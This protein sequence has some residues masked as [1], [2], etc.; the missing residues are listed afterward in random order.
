M[1]PGLGDVVQRCRV[2]AMA[3]LPPSR[4][5]PGSGGRFSSGLGDLAEIL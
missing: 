2:R 4:P 1:S 5:Q 3:A